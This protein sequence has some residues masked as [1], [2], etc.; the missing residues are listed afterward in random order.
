MTAEQYLRQRLGDGI[1]ADELERW[2][3]SLWCEVLSGA[4]SYD[5]AFDG[6]ENLLDLSST[7]WRG[8]ADRVI[9]AGPLP[10]G[11]ILVRPNA[12]PAVVP[13]VGAPAGTGTPVIFRASRSGARSAG[14][15]RPKPP[16]GRRS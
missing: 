14:P 2:V 12:P 5:P 9:A 4:A 10:P 13:T 1:P 7:D 15:G 8:Y 11:F 16:W 6:T 3:V